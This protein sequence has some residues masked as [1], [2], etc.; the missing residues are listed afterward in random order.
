[1]LSSLVTSQYSIHCLLLILTEFH[2]VSPSA[3]FV[4]KVK[5]L[6]TAS[7]FAEFD[8]SMILGLGDLLSANISC[9]PTVKEANFA[10]L[11]DIEINK[12]QLFVVFVG[13]IH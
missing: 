9:S 1:M 13:K 10:S 3:K 7:Y 6:S 2:E 8:Y 5:I 4:T 11:C 12:I